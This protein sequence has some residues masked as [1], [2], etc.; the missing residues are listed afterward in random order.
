MGLLDLIEKAINEHGSATI[1]K[2]R[3]ELIREQAQAREKQLAALQEE[4][5]ALRRGGA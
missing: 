4:N 3:L 2:E 1:M 5:T